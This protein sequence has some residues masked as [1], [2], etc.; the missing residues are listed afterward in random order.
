MFAFLDAVDEAREKS[1]ASDTAEDSQEDLWKYFED[2]MSDPAKETQDKD[3]GVAEV[4]FYSLLHGI[5]T[6]VDCSKAIDV[7]ILAPVYSS[8]IR[9]LNNPGDLHLVN[10]NDY[11]EDADQWVICWARCAH[12]VVRNER[13]VRDGTYSAGR[14]L[15][16][17]IEMVAFL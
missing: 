15:M 3:R 8:I 2:E 9:H 16:S 5:C 6:D 11:Q 1:F 7:H 12:V 17:R 13:R 4:R 14:L 10:V